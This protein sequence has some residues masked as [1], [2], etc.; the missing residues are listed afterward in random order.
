MTHSFPSPCIGVCKLDKELKVCIGCNRTLKQ[1]AEQGAQRQKQ[2]HED[3]KETFYRIRHKP[4]G[5]FFKPSTHRSKANLSK[6]GKI[7][8]K[9][10]NSSYLGSKYHYPTGIHHSFYEARE[11]DMD[12][13]EIVEYKVEEI[14]T[15]SL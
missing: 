5:L 10:P 1:I 15:E 2:M 8:Y 11:V 14:S 3:A 9:K 12:D 6:Q 13:W 4:T 7:Y